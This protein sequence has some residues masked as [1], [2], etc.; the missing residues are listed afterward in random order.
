MLDLMSEQEATFLNSSLG[1]F[2]NVQD[3]GRAV[4]R[5]NASMVRAYRPEHFYSAL[6]N[7]D[8]ILHL[9]AHAD[10]NSL[11]V[12]AAPRVAAT[13][14][15]ERA[16]KGLRMPEVVVSTA[17]KFDSRAW[18]ECLRNLGVKVLIAAAASVSPANLV[19]FD[20][21]FYSALLSQVR[22]GATTIERVEASFTLADRHY[23]DVHAL[24]TPFAKFSLTH[25]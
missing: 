23:R 5:A 12:G 11:Q 4:P 14:L 21:A 6:A 2:R 22:K 7:T 25:L 9:I 15:N 20:M 18:R 10:G 16:A 24:G 13:E 8:D 17:C 19:A 1:L 3:L